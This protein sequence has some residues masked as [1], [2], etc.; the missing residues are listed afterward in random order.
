[1]LKTVL[2]TDSAV[3]P[4]TVAEV[5]AH[6]RISDQYEDSLIAGLI[7]AAR[8]SV[9]QITRRSL[10]NQ[11][12]RLYLDDFPADIYI[13][14]PYPPLVSV[15]HVKYYDQDGQFVTLN[16]ADYQV[17]DKATPG[18]IVLTELGNWPTTELDK[19]NAVEVEFVAGYGA[20]AV[21]I[22]G[23]IKLAITH[24]VSHWFENREPYRDGRM[25]AIPATFEMIL[26]PYRFL[27]LR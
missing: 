1:M 13:N 8:K 21:N 2:V 5:K 23:P 6:L 4:I 17:D 12:W 20:S 25:E 14:L 7:T 24:L 27:S 26:M 10:I 19:V 15:T 9:E 22:P 18:S 3:E 11:T 16:T